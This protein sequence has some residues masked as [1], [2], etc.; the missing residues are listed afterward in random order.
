[1]QA[2]TE[3][4]AIAKQTEPSL[5]VTPVGHE[6]R[7]LESVRRIDGREMP[8]SNCCLSEHT[9]QSGDNAQQDH[10]PDTH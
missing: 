7:L 3:D 6:G 8:G 1:M 2:V 5:S 10:H 9:Q 4:N